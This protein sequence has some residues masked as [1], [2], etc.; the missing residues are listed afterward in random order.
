MLEE[1]SS[2]SREDQTSPISRGDVVICDWLQAEFHRRFDA[3]SIII[4]GADTVAHGFGSGEVQ[5]VEEMVVHQ[6]A[7]ILPTLSTH[8]SFRRWLSIFWG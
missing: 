3:P 5:D 6:L 2:L 1:T 4:E 8:G 7:F